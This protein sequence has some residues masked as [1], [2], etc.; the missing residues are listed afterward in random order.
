MFFLFRLT[1]Q[2]W[3]LL[4]GKDPEIDPKLLVPPR[5]MDRR[6]LQLKKESAQHPRNLAVLDPSPEVQNPK[7]QEKQRPVRRSE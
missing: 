4:P 7:P 6:Q 2:W 3:L 1:I 5:L